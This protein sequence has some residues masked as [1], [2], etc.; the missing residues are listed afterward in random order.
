MQLISGFVDSYLKLNESENRLFIEQIATI[1]PKEKE[2]VM[3][4]VTSWMEEGI[5]IGRQ[6]GR[7]ESLLKLI[8]RQLAWRFDQLAP[9]LEER[10]SGLNSSQLEVLGLE[11]LA[12]ESLDNLITWLAK[13]ESKTEE[14][15]S[16]RT[17]E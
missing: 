6:E 16:D 12:F 5:E 14:S 8:L 1:K 7:Q 9:D 17:E 11:M 13:I 3:Q 15:E 4:I 2:E 10:V